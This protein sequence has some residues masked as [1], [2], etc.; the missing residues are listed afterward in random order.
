[1]ESQPR[2]RYLGC[3]HHDSLQVESA[4]KNR[5][6]HHFPFWAPNEFIANTQHHLQILRS[7]RTYSTSL[8]ELPSC[9]KLS[10]NSRRCLPNCF[11]LPR[12]PANPKTYQYMEKRLF[13]QLN[14]NR[15]VIGILRGH[16]V[17]HPWPSLCV[18]RTEIRD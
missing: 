2:M 13:V 1:M 15:K 7:H 3:Q 12:K 6:W 5:S 11:Y 10:P 17:S 14:G 9:L 18:L 4:V 16:D 8:P